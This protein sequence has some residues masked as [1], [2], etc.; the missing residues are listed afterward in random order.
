MVKYNTIS[1]NQL[2]NIHHICDQDFIPKLSSKVNIEVYCKKLHS[3]STIITL[4]NN[5]KDLLGLV[6]VYVNNEETR[7]AYIS[8]VCILKQHWGKGLGKLL[9]KETISFVAKKKFRS[10]KLEV[11]IENYVAIKLYNSFN[12]KVIEKGLS[13]QIMQL[14]L[15]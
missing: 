4:H 10:I 8:S 7:V 5:D 12:F 9:L 11:G 15:P 14:E 1:L 3:N 2:I 13:T 6:A